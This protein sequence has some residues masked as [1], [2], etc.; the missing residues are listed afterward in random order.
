[1]CQGR[2]LYPG[3]AL[4]C[5]ISHSRELPLEYSCIQ[6]KNLR[7]SEYR[8][9][10]TILL[11]VHTLQITLSMQS[12]AKRTVLLWAGCYWL[13]CG[14]QLTP[15]SRSISS[16]SFGN[17]YVDSE[18]LWNLR[19]CRIMSEALLF[20][21]WLVKELGWDGTGETGFF[22]CPDFASE[23]RLYA[24]ETLLPMV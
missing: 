1:M 14:T 10:A 17:Q 7:V 8:N 16:S 13:L 22:L 6:F 2:S 3:F 19:P 4:A 11:S 20:D 24:A 15:T 9:R 18:K 23:C 5:Q 21:S 12:V